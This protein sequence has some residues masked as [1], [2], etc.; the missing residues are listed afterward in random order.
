MARGRPC[1]NVQQAQEG[2]LWTTAWR[3]PFGNFV[4]L[5]KLVYLSE[6][7]FLRLQK[8]MENSIYLTGLLQGTSKAGTIGNKV[9]VI[10][11]C[12]LPNDSYE[13]HHCQGSDF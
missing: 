7:Q 10:G 3:L 5:G 4:T 9:S 6:P 12:Y 8:G 1:G 11:T 13:C 2:Q